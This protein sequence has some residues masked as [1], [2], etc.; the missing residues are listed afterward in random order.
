MLPGDPT[1]AVSGF[2]K[3]QS[4]AGRDAPRRVAGIGRQ[5]ETIPPDTHLA[6]THFDDAA[7]RQLNG[8]ITEL[9]ADLP[10]GH[11]GISSAERGQNTSLGR[12]PA[13]DEIGD[14]VFPV[15]MSRPPERHSV[16]DAICRKVT[17]DFIDTEPRSG[18]NE[19]PHCPFIFC[20]PSLFVLPVSEH[21]ELDHCAGWLRFRARPSAYKRIRSGQ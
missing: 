18:S 5:T 1:C 2:D 20:C 3:D 21:H 11:H 7:T 13:S 6:T 19:A 14:E 9:R 12:C 10:I 17:G 8:T 16:A 4:P 15:Y